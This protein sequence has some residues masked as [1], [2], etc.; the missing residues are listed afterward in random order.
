M[1]SSPHRALSHQPPPW[2]TLHSPPRLKRS[3]TPQ[4]ALVRTWPLNRSLAPVPDRAQPTTASSYAFPLLS[5]CCC[6]YHII[7]RPTRLCSSLMHCPAVSTLT[8]GTIHHGP[9]SPGKAV[10]KHESQM[11]NWEKTRDLE[12]PSCPRPDLGPRHSCS[13]PGPGP[14]GPPAP[15]PVLS[16]QPL[17][18]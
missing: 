15:A 14:L 9:R 4:Q 17:A 16:A 6:P 3:P 13:V 5:G 7:S 10:S 2:D 1:S 12:T 8:P 18:P 11:S